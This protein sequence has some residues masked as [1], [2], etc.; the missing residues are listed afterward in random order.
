MLFDV[1]LVFFNCFVSNSG[2]IYRLISDYLI[3]FVKFKIKK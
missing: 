3:V 1:I 2:V